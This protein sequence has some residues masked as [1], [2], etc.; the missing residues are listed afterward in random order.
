[1]TALNAMTAL[2][3]AAL[4]SGLCILWMVV[5]SFRTIF[6]RRSL[7]VSF[8]DGGDAVLTSRSRAFGNA[9]E[10]IPAC[11]AI[12]ILM[13][14]SGFQPMWIHAVGGAMFLGRVLHAWGLAQAKQPSFGRM[15][16]MILT[17]LALIGGAGALIACALGYL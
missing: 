7:R 9:S 5:L 10:Y 15:S 3:A 11:L 1:M 12:L 16:G 13:A 17:Q 4:W 6:A 8:G 14:L 2:Q